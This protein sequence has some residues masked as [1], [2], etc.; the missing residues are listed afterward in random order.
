M[1]PETMAATRSPFRNLLYRVLAFL[2]VLVVGRFVLEVAGVP[3]S[4]TR[5]FSSTVGVFLA[6]IYLAAVAPLRGGLQKV[7]QL[8]LPALLISAWTV[9]CIVVMT[10]I[11]AVFRIERSHFAMKE[12][13]GNWGQLGQHL[14]GHLVEIVVFFVLTFIIMAAIQVLWRWPVTVGPG[15]ILG[16]LVIMRYWLEAMGLDAVRT[17]PW[18]STMGVILSAFFLGA[19]APRV[20]LTTA[21]QLIAP[22]LA[23]A[24]VWRFWIFLATLLSA[25]VPFY[26]T[27]FFDPSQGQVAGRLLRFFLGGVIVEGLVVALIVWGTAIWISRATRAVSPSA[28]PPERREPKIEHFGAIGD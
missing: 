23:I 10:V 9:G 12:D 24:F 22:S 18:S 14:L 20:G 15:A 11:S 28:Q 19:L 1:S 13:Y 2:G 7:K 3:E 25:L 4:V 16:A 8:P 26:K 27:H 5:Y 17:A 21:R 6:A